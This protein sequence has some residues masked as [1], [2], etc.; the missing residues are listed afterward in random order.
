MAKNDHACRQ[1]GKIV[2][3]KDKQGK[4]ELRADTDKETLWATQAQIAQLFETT[5]QNIT[6]HI[7]KIYGSGELDEK[8][9]CK[10]YLQVQKERSRAVKRKIM[11]YNLDVII[12]VGYRVNSM[13]AT[14]FRI[15][16]TG[17]LREY[18]I[19]GFT[20]DK[21][22]LADSPERVEGLREA[23]AFM[24]SNEYP[25]KVKGKVTLKVVKHL[26][27]KDEE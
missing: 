10:E 7:K 26:E 3:Y 4:V 12:A 17:I 19:K 6:V 23:V 20:I 25:G 24:E 2:L 15:W 1:A 22:K 9:T 18:L 8:A 27:T 21:R 16:A 14:Q 13:K 11:H 5:P